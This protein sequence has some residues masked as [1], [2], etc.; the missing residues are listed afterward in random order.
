MSQRKKRG[1]NMPSGNDGEG[2]QQEVEEGRPKHVEDDSPIGPEPE[3]QRWIDRRGH[4][5]EGECQQHRDRIIG[6]PHG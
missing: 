5:H 2:D 1:T 4:A 3:L 6:P